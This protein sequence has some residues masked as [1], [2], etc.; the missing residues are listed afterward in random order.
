LDSLIYAGDQAISCL[1][2]TP[3]GGWDEGKQRPR[4]LVRLQG[5][6]DETICPTLAAAKLKEG[7]VV[8]TAT[9]TSGCCAIP[10]DLPSVPQPTLACRVTSASSRP[11]TS[12]ASCYRN[13]S[14]SGAKASSSSR[15]AT[16]PCGATGEPRALTET[17]EPLDPLAT[18][19]LEM[20]RRRKPVGQVHSPHRPRTTAENVC[21]LA[22]RL[23]QWS[24]RNRTRHHDPQQSRRKTEGNLRQSPQE[25]APAN[26]VKVHRTTVSDRTLLARYEN[27]YSIP[28]EV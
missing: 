11:D 3:V 16:R 27:P 14:S 18:P 2:L 1:A 26:P 8:I 22:P 7:Q 4:R 20:R 10:Q 15:Q 5:R 28:Q 17:R 6:A 25:Q 23:G 13:R 21:R 24:T 9:T 12:Q 19:R